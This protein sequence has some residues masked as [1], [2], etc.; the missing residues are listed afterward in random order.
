M[1]QLL[2]HLRLRRIG[3]CYR[4]SCER[5]VFVQQV[6]RAPVG[7]R[8][9]RHLRQ[10]LKNGRFVESG[11]KQLVG[12]TKDSRSI[13]EDLL[14]VNI[15]DRPDPLDHHAVLDD[16]NAIRAEP[17]IPAGRSA[18][19]VLCFVHARLFERSGPLAFRIGAVQR[20]NRIQPAPAPVLLQ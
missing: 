13:L 20:V 4:N 10:P 12:V 16:R 1:Q 8:G 6:D 15:R 9:H 2:G 7:E 19:T 5:P 11:S 14:R 18:Q 3:V 17:A